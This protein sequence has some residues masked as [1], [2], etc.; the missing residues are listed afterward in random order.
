MT[1]LLTEAQ[2]TAKT[3]QGQLLP[4]LS[5]VLPQ[6]HVPFA[7]LPIKNEKKLDDS[8]S[9]A[10]LHSKFCSKSQINNS[11]FRKLMKKTFPHDAHP[12][13]SQ[14]ERHSLFPLA[15]PSPRRLRVATRFSFGIALAL[16]SLALPNAS[17]QPFASR[18]LDKEFETSG[19]GLPNKNPSGV[20]MDKDRRVLLV[21]DHKSERIYSYSVHPD[22]ENP[23]R[24][25]LTRLDNHHNDSTN[26][27]EV[28]ANTDDFLL[29]IPTEQVKENENTENEK[30]VTKQSLRPYGIW[31]NGTTSGSTLWVSYYRTLP[32]GNGEIRAY[33][34]TWTDS[35]KTLPEGA[36]KK[37]ATGTRISSKD[38]T[39]AKDED[40]TDT[41]KPHGIWAN[42]EYM[43]VADNRK[44]RIYAYAYNST[45]GKY[46]RT[47]DSEKKDLWRDG[48]DP[49]YHEADL[50]G[51]QG[52]WSDGTTIWVSSFVGSS[53]G[54]RQK[55]YAYNVATTLRDPAKDFNNLS[56][57]GNDKPRGIWS[58][59]ETM[60]VVDQTDNKFYA[61]HAFL[62]PTTRNENQDFETL[63]AAGNNVPEGMWSDGQTLWV[64][65][66]GD[67]KLY[68]YD[69]ATTDHIPDK[70]FNT[71]RAAGNDKPR[72]IW[73][74]G[75]TMWVANDG[76]DNSDDKLYAYDLITKTNIPDKN[77]NTLSA[78]GNNAPKGMWSDRE[79]L[80]VA[81][82]SDD[83]LY[84]YDLTT[85][86]N[87][88]GKEITTESTDAKLNVDLFKSYIWS[89]GITMWVSAFNRNGTSDWTAAATNRED[90]TA[91]I[92]AYNMWTNN[93]QGNPVWDGSRDTD[94]EFGNLIT[95]NLTYNGNDRPH[96]IW[97]DGATMWVAEKDDYLGGATNKIYA[98]RLS[99]A[100]SLGALELTGHVPSREYEDFEEIQLHPFFDSGTTRYTASVPYATESLTVSPRTLRPVDRP[101]NGVFS[102]SPV[103]A[104]A[105][106]D[107]HQVNLTV[108]DNLISITVT[109]GQA[110]G[111][112]RTR[113]YTVDVTREFFTYNDPSKDV[114]LSTSWIPTNVVVR[115]LWTDGTTMWLSARETTTTQDQNGESTDTHS[116]KLYSYNLQSSNVIS[117]NN[118]THNNPYGIWSD[119]TTMWIADDSSDDD[120]L[121]AYELESGD[122]LNSTNDFNLDDANA[123]P[124]WIWSDGETMWV[125]NYGDNT[126]YAYGMSNKLP[127]PTKNINIADVD[128]AT[129]N[130]VGL[131]SDGASL[132]IADNADDKLF[133]YKLKTD[134]SSYTIHCREETKD[135][136]TL[137]AAKNHNPEAIFSDGS[138]MWV[139][140]NT[141]KKIFA[142]NQPL[143]ANNKLKRLELSNV[144]S[145]STSMRIAEVFSG[146]TNNYSAYV[147][148]TNFSTT[149]TAIAQDPDAGVAIQPKD[150]DAN[151]DGH[152]INLA[153]GDN[154]ITI[155]VTAE[156]AAVQ[157]YTV[158][159]TRKS[160]GRTPIKDVALWMK[161]NK[162]RGIWSDG[163]TWQVANVNED[164]RRIYVYNQNSANFLTL[165]KTNVLNEN[166]ADPQGLWSDNEKELWVTDGEDR[167][168]YV[169]DLSGTG[170]IRR[171]NIPRPPQINRTTQHKPRGLWSN[172]TTLWLANAG[173]GTNNNRRIYAYN[174]NRSGANLVAKP[175][176]NITLDGSN[177]EPRELWSNGTTMWV[178]DTQK[179]MQRIYAYNISGGHDANKDIDIRSV[180]RSTEDRGLWSDGLTTMWV[181]GGRKLHAFNLPQPGARGGSGPSEDASLSDLR[182]SG[183]VLSPAF[184]PANLNYAAQV[185]S[186]VTSATVTAVANDSGAVV[187]ILW[188]S[189]PAATIH[190]AKRGSQ[191]SLE[192]GYNLIV[193]DVTAENG[194]VESYFVEITKAEAPPVSG[195]P[196]PQQPQSFQP[197][198]TSSA[199]QPILASSAAGLG[200]WKSR[201]IFA[202]SLLDGDVRFVFLVPPEELKIEETADLL[203]GNWRP[204]PEAGVKILRESNGAGQ[205][206]L[207][208]ILQ[209]AAGKQRFLRLMPLTTTVDLNRTITP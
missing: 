207:T 109:N 66:D 201:L 93:V 178:E 70:D 173:V 22:P 10:K 51:I 142:Y 132:W 126:I 81:D 174:H 180:A 164:E 116:G 87:I 143:S 136:N 111:L 122:R 120:K 209:K 40:N 171:I 141:A 35:T 150:A 60:W 17:A 147:V 88:P 184:S 48:T 190:T 103:D 19:Y 163:T 196:L 177:S 31:A 20:W 56:D 154:T 101:T 100:A 160:G 127:A 208:I 124:R 78:A 119:G 16:L 157:E 53:P 15:V 199:N 155:T 98:Y 133:A 193:V 49:N 113:T 191:V 46:E 54:D 198:A 38:V 145:E 144:Y 130:R 77:F 30:T 128:T 75:E 84:A 135:F 11:H 115:G 9:A 121:Y 108:G 102:I 94:K 79:T 58:D 50:T 112:P 200:E 156:N 67:D 106:K 186:D 90:D 206:R 137:K 129:A 140:D 25:A 85:K 80:W 123:N 110:T 146:V 43:Y 192:E 72:G 97:S 34:L 61:Y 187:D 167:Q 158:N 2:K 204:L 195:G 188:S 118:L 27:N 168:I 32:G 45:R 179:D 183:V 37:Y 92:Y 57:V 65:D 197:L 162:P 44:W 5:D 170:L 131:W 68:A 161:N 74:D 63:K 42:D 28:S 205:V 151:T 24:L 175:T 4:P 52:V 202:E 182:L 13:K 7:A 189:N 148:Y 83:K 1:Y 12:T 185:D 41:R 64:A 152:Q 21:L 105:T 69:L 82:D 172:G 91:G 3:R 71:L 138:T 169:Y 181:A 203:G 99:N 6:N 104:D 166:N 153:E 107:G 73:S 159:V 134:V 23:E 59:G 36:W 139:V 194:I 62:S 165:S 117:T 76:D 86:T 96:G 8:Q 149:V 14:E 125:T 47:A 95:T 33:T 39:V 29:E 89:D 26:T 55:I 114:A 176:K 18:D